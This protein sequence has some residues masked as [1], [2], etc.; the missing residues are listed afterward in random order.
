MGSSG[1]TVNA[2]ALGA[3]DDAVAV[4]TDGTEVVGE[5]LTITAPGQAA[6]QAPAGGGGGGATLRHESFTGNNTAGPFTL[7]NTPLN[8]LVQAF[9]RGILHTQGTHFTV[10]G[11][12]V[13]F[14]AL[15]PTG[16]PIEFYYE[17]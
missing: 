7:S 1:G 5:V 11:N 8:G 15:I 3:G 4:Q 12:G 16:D 17:T 2:S 10:L 9:V 6:F 13:T 14:D